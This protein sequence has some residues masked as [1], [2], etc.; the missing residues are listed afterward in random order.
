MKTKNQPK[1]SND[2]DST[3][4]D[5]QNDP[6]LD[7]RFDDGEET[8]CGSLVDLTM[9]TDD[10][11]VTTNGGD[12]YEPI[13]LPL[14]ETVTESVNHVSDQYIASL[15]TVA[16]NHIEKKRKRKLSPEE[17]KNWHYFYFEKSQLKKVPNGC[18]EKNFN[19]KLII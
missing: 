3:S 5:D 9:D 14:S 13:L 10:D 18:S 8:V 4:S 16:K 19:F 17:K 7:P 11:S 15:E 1:K 2:S 6:Y 12:P